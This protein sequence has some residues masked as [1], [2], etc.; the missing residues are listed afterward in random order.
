MNPDKLLVISCVRVLQIVILKGRQGS[1][2]GRI[3]SGAQQAVAAAASLAK[4]PTPVKSC[5]AS[6]SLETIFS[7]LHPIIF[8]S[9]VLYTNQKS[10]W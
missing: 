7:F 10:Y 2:T 9:Y 4:S 3:C 8:K 1:P 5:F 6:R